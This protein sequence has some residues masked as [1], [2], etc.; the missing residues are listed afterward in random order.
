MKTK[1]I[2]QQLSDS[3]ILNP[4]LPKVVKMRI[5]SLQKVEYYSRI[6]FE[7]KLKYLKKSLI[8]HEF[9]VPIVVN[10]RLDNS[11]VIIDGY[12]R[13]QLWLELGNEFVPT[14]LLRESEA[15]EK[16]LH[17]SLNQQ[18]FDFDIG[19]MLEFFEQDCLSDYGLGTDMEDY[20]DETYHD[21]REKRSYHVQKEKQ[22][23][24]IKRMRIAFFETDYEKAKHT[25]SEIRKQHN[26]EN[27]AQ[28]INWL[29]EKYD[30]QNKSM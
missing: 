13:S 15:K 27:D 12:Q 7:G 28:A 10:R 18:A 14:I 1:E 22:D 30:G 4:K 21:K 6:P 3:G 24:G 8:N 2:Y 26:L 17:I 5:D 16:E 19:S 29:I 20:D 9:I 23:K 25:F 11:L